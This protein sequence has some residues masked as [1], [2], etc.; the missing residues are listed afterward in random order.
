MADKITTR[1]LRNKD[2]IQ[3][4]KLDTLTLVGLGG[5]GSFLVQGLATMG[6]DEVIGYD[7][8]IVENHNLSSTCYPIED[9]GKQ[10]AEASTLLFKRYAEEWQTFIGIPERFNGR[11]VITPKTIVC[12]DNMESRL[13][14]YNKWKKLDNRQIL[15]DARMG[16]TSVELVTVTKDND[17]YMDSWIPTTSVPSAP[18]SM[19]H[20]VFATQHIVSITLAQL[21]NLV[22][23]LAYHDYTWAS[24]TPNITEYGNLIVPQI[25]D[26]A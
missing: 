16:A 8:D 26:T 17:N 6:W 5:I 25:G 11:R 15:L 2:L 23:N 20:T 21:Y 10:K 9:V 24:L 12:T 3:Q 13:A 22:A 1:F 18:C 4:D 7:D 14:V 19:K